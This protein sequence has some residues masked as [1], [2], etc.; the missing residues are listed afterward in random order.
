V[1]S[2]QEFYQAGNSSNDGIALL[3]GVNRSGNR[4][5]WIGDSANLTQNS[6]N[7]LI[8]IY[9]SDNRIDCV[10]TNGTTALPLNLGSSTTATAVAGLL[11]SNNGYYI[12]TANGQ[13][14]VTSGSTTNVNW[15]T[16]SYAGTF[17]SGGLALSGPG[18]SVWNVFTNNSGVTQKWLVTYGIACSGNAGTIGAWILAS[19][20]GNRW[21]FSQMALPGGTTT[22]MSGSCLIEMP[23]GGNIRIQFFYQ[24]GSPNVTI[25][26]TTSSLSITLIA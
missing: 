20:S 10:A 14:I 6:S 5:L 12:A 2:G 16:S 18:G 15:V 1:L 3:C 11:S 23:N 4:Q 22:A 26:T 21:G 8:R 24:A 7:K 9:P 17:S 19:T 13:T 25:A